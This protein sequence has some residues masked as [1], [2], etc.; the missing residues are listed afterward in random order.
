MTEKLVWRVVKELG[1]TEKN[2]SSA[3]PILIRLSINDGPLGDQ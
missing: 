1:S 2:D 3:T